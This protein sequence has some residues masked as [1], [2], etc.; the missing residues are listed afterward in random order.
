M[1]MLLTGTPGLPEWTDGSALTA[2]RAGSPAAPVRCSAPIPGS[3]GTRVSGSAPSTT[4]MV[5]PQGVPAA[6]PAGVPQRKRKQH[7]DL[8][9]QR[10]R[11]S[12]GCG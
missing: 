8:D 9:P 2:A 6:R 3:R 7:I 11:P 12:G 4:S 10:P 5:P 1:K